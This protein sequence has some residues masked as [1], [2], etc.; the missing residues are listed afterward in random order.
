MRIT[1]DI[2]GGTDTAAVTS[3]AVKTASS[4][5]AAAEWTGVDGGPA[6]TGAAGAVGATTT[7]DTNPS[8]NAYSG[9]AVNA[10]AAPPSL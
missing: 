3:P 8:S 5:P 9:D 4:A 2:D 7:N 6:P 10:G 1:I